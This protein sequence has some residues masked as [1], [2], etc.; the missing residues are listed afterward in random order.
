[1]VGAMARGVAEIHVPERLSSGAGSARSIASSAS[2]DGDAVLLRIRTERFV[3]W[4]GWDSGTV[5]LA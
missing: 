5:V 2:I 1:M 3:W 4:R